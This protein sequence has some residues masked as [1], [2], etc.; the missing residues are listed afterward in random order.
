MTVITGKV[1]NAATGK[2]V[3]NAHVFFT[4][5]RGKS[6]SPLKGTVT[7][8]DGNYSFDSLGGYYLKATHIGYSDVLKP[9]D[10]S[11][12]QSGGDYANILNFRLPATAYGLPEVVIH[13][14]SL[15]NRS[16]LTKNKGTVLMLGGMALTSY[17]LFRKRK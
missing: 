11:R 12:F 16:W 15:D 7:D 6:Y 14:N 5:K 10:L 2:P 13:G 8:F 17:V 9:I 1:V 4:D 3:Y